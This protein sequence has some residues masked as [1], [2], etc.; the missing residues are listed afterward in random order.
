[1]QIGPLTPVDRES[2]EVLFRAYI[3]FYERTM[4][5]ERY[6]R[7]WQEFIGDRRLGARARLHAPVLEHPGPGL[8]GC[9]TAWPSTAGS[10]ATT[11][12]CDA[13]A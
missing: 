7:A 9:M 11:W 8:G 10:S 3:D 5:D 12:I 1:V 13:T 4:P 6:D 2:W